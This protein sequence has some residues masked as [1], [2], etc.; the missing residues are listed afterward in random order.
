M[1]G[2]APVPIEGM[3][4]SKQRVRADSRAERKRN[5]LS[6]KLALVLKS[7]SVRR[8]QVNDFGK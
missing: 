8:H 6:D 7:T 3:F 4:F 5:K 2:G 1:S